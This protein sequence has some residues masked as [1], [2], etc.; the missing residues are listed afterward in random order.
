[1]TVSGDGVQRVDVR[2]M[3]P[4]EA[5][6]FTPWLAEH[7]DLLGAELGLTLEEVGQEVAVG[8]YFLDIFAKASGGH[9]GDVRV[10]IENQ[11]EWS[12]LQ[13]L[14][15]LLTY[16]TGL[17]ARVAVWVAP[18][19]RRQLAEAL[20]RLNEWTRDGISF[21]GVKV[22]VLRRDGSAE[23][24]PRFRK[25]VWPG[26]WDED[27]TALDGAQSEESRLYDDF[28]QPLIAELVR[29]GFAAGARR[30]FDGTGRFFTPG[31]AEGTGYAASL[32]GRNDAWV[33]L[34][35]RTDDVEQANR[36]FDELHAA[37][38]E[39]ESEF[40]E[41]LGDREQADTDASAP[42]W[43][44]GRYSPYPFASISIRRDGAI[45][46]PSE[47][48]EAIRAWMLVHLP[49]LKA[50]FDPR[51]EAILGRLSA[52]GDSL[53]REDGMVT[54]G[55][56]EQATEVAG[57][58][59][60]EFG[61]YGR[62]LWRTKGTQQ[63]A[64]AA[65]ARPAS[66][67]HPH[68]G[69][70]AAEL[71][72]RLLAANWPLWGSDVEHMGIVTISDYRWCAAQGQRRDMSGSEMHVFRHGASEGHATA[73]DV[74]AEGHIACTASAP[75]EADDKQRAATMETRAREG[76]RQTFVAGSGPHSTTSRLAS[77]RYSTRARH[78]IGL[79]QLPA[80]RERSSN[81]VL[82]LR[83]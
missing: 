50:V 83:R 28:F 1:M 43:N 60:R 16:A 71:R 59:A 17:D 24:E 74:A 37:R 27:S 81:W 32:Q 45:H 4:N 65:S 76:L 53:A 30:H 18:E 73:C 10:V 41:L 38:Q 58:A 20:H 54:E 25:V 42:E 46:D 80:S 13:H 7:L 62:R 6:D 2:S 21:Y 56:Q 35:I 61:N 48:L 29:T 68:S 57:I 34:H 3:W 14:G 33:T 77:P 82:T 72:E 47:V 44:W 79:P 15:Q 12:D 26:G 78:G 22:E 40:A 49:G 63:A 52:G 64:F 5:Y 39:I 23:L 19:F 9:G 69:Y 55:K 11:L 75:N 51:V 8:P 70:T 67:P 36:I 66:D 31:I